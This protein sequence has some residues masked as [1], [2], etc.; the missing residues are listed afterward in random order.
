MKFKVV[1]AV[2]VCALFVVALEGAKDQTAAQDKA[3]G[4]TA[5]P[6]GETAA[7]KPETGQEAEPEVPVWLESDEQKICYAFA[8]KVAGSL[9]A[10]GIEEPDRETF[11]RGLTDYLQGEGYALSEEQME[12]AMNDFR[13]RLAARRDAQ[14][15][16]MARENI[17]DAKDFLKENKEKPGV[18]VLAEGVQYEVLKEG[19]GARPG[20]QDTVKVHYRGTL[21]NGMEFD[22]SYKRGAPAEFALNRVIKG[23]QLALQQ[24]K[25]GAKWRIYVPPELGYGER[26]TR[27]IPPNSALIFEVELLDIVEPTAGTPGG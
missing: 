15:Q 6:A 7:A 16:Q 10:A 18:K 22:S 26:G 13:Q 24:M 2:F 12:N 1:A 8:T 3:A 14:M 17:A 20:P 23:W 11:M 21:T 9:R 4:E 27:S 25:E 19:S 5:T